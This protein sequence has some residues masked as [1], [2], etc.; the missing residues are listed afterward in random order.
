MGTHAT[1]RLLASTWPRH[2]VAPTAELRSA[3]IDDRLLA[4]AVRSGLLLRLRHGAYIP[5][6]RCDALTPWEREVARLDAHVEATGGASVY[7]LASAAVLHGCSVWNV[8]P[9]IHVATTYAGSRAS[10]SSD[11]A[12]HQLFLAEHDLTLV[13]RRGRHLKATTLVRTAADCA[14]TMP[15]EQAVVM[16]DSALQR[17]LDPRALR[18]EVEQGSPRGRRRALDVVDSLEPATES[19]GE[20]RTRMLLERLGFEKPHVQFEV[21]TAAGVY[22]ADFA[23]PRLMVIIEFEGE[24]KYRNHGP[25]SDV[26]LAERRRETLLMEQGWVFV[27]LRWAD[28]EK[29]D[30]VRRRIEAAI[31]TAARRS[32]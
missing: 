12:T 28:L 31:Q 19:V 15:F 13:E 14:R 16:G 21:E 5:A 2:D 4:K 3:G 1:E 18:R 6:H 7:C 9:E 10:R 27:R 24:G 30:E 17:G 26:L 8:G 11:T 25:A 29:P 32:A 22:R 20:T 23:W